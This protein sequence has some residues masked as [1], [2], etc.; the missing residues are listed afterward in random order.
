VSRKNRQRRGLTSQQQQQEHQQRPNIPPQLAE[1]LNPSNPEHAVI[2]RFMA[3]L[4][5]LSYSGPLPPPDVLQK[6]NEIEPG[7]VDR[8][9][10][11]AE[12]QAQHRHNLES[13][14]IGQRS[15]NE[16]LG[17]TYG[18]IIAGMAIV[19]S[20]V[21]IGLGK[22]AIGLTGLLGTIGTLAG[23]FV[24]GRRSQRLENAEKRG[25]IAKPPEP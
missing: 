20:F 4:Q 11:M 24:Y 10:K 15:K 21:L 2:L 14:V 9:M 18:F 6:Y 23:V 3:S 13:F 8:I 19:G 25:A 7:L 17:A 1:L 5:V 22:D 12:S 16:R